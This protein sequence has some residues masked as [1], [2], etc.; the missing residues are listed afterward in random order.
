[1]EQ[2]KMNARQWATYNLIKKRSEQ[3]LE[4]TQERVYNN[5]A[6]E[7]HED[8]YSWAVGRNTHDRCLKVWED[9]HFIN[10][11]SEVEK[12]IIMDK[13]TYRI[14]T[15]EEA[16]AYFEKLREK[17]I[18]AFSRAYNVK[19]KI[20]ADGQGKLI[21]CQGKEIDGESKARRFVETFLKEI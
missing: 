12:I 20:K 5:Y 10:A 6:I 19:R 14:A 21:S 7:D 11:S 18:K 4:T 2:A 9:V 15:E 8:G 3:G 16:N 17:A 13:F 1:M